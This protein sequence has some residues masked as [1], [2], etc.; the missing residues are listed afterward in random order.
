MTVELGLNV[1]AFYQRRAYFPFLSP[2]LVNWSILAIQE[3]E[4]VVANN[5]VND[6][7][8]SDLN[9]YSL[10]RTPL[11]TIPCGWMSML[12]NFYF[13]KTKDWFFLTFTSGFQHSS[14]SGV[15]LQAHPLVS[16]VP[17]CT[18]LHGLVDKPS[19]GLPPLFTVVPI[20]SMNMS[21]FAFLFHVPQNKL[22][23]SSC[24]H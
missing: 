24:A 17:A 23:I 18:F 7:S 2:L 6:L 3:Y 19:T 22:R 21:T 20:F 9:D 4:Y 12:I 8:L 1:V 13:M 5:F 16:T 14:F 10:P 15:G 11:P